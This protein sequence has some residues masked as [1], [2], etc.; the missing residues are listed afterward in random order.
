MLGLC[1]DQVVMV[2][3]ACW[4][5]PRTAT[6]K[7]SSCSLVGFSEAYSISQQCF[8]LKKTSISQSKPAPA[9]TSEHARTHTL[10]RQAQAHPGECGLDGGPGRN[11][12]HAC[13]PRSMAWWWCC[14]YGPWRASSPLQTPASAVDW[15]GGRGIQEAA[16]KLP[17]LPMHAHSNSTRTH[18]CSAT[19]TAS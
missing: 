10:Q 16:P 11:Q 9:P 7:Q 4:L 3:A 19:P 1:M 14:A 12:S 18:A 5:S 6:T 8:S 17:S 13:R 15:R 2:A